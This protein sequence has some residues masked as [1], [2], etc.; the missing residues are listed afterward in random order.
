VGACRRDAGRR[1]DADRQRQEEKYGG[2]VCCHKA[3]RI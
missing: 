3:L 1:R 2:L